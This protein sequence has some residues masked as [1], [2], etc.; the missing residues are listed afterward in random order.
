[1]KRITLGLLFAAAVIAAGTLTR[2]TESGDGDPI[3]RTVLT[4]V[5]GVLVLW[6]IADFWQRHRA[7][8]DRDTPTVTDSSNTP[9]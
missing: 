4:A 3:V 6:K 9:V 8:T 5:I 1:M 7:G 2:A